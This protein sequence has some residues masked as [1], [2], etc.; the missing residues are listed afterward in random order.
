MNQKFAFELCILFCFVSVFC[1][2][3]PNS[4]IYGQA[5][6]SNT[7]GTIKAT[8]NKSAE[9]ITNVYSNPESGVLNLHC[10]S[11][12]RSPIT[13]KALN[14]KDI[15][16]KLIN[17]LTAEGSANFKFVQLNTAGLDKGEYKIIMLDAIGKTI[18]RKIFLNK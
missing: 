4:T 5:N 17:S 7:N 15:V 1:V 16:V 14:A 3:R 13:I 10:C 11:D 12:F 9:N 18:T 6:P 2:L 8:C